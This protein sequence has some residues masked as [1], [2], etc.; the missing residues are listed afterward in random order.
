MAV[1]VIPTII[2]S[3]MMGVMIF[4]LIELNSQ[5]KKRQSF[6]LAGLLSLLLIHILG[7]LFIYSGAYR[8]APSLAGAQFPMRM[9]LGPAL[10]FYAF[11]SMSPKKSPP[12]MAWVLAVLGPMVVIL[13]MLPFVL[14]ISAQEKLALANP[15]TRDAEL[16]KVALFT[17]LFAMIAFIVF[18][19]IYLIAAFKL[20]QQHRR[21]LMERFADIEKRAMDWFSVLL[22]LWSCVWLLFAIDFS[23][24]FLG[25]KW[26]GTG[27][28]LP[29]AEALVLMFFCHFALRQPNINDADK[30]KPSSESVRTP[31][32]T[33]SKMKQIASK[34]QNIIAENALFLEDDLSLNKLS[35]AIAVSENHISETLSQY[36]QTNFFQFVNSYRV[37]HAMDLLISTNKTVTNIAFDAGFN[38]KSTF[39]TAFKK[40][41]GVTPTAYRNEA[42]S[43]A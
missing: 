7:E 11:A 32:L 6:Y 17:C 8:Y 2:Y 31:N 1:H 33:T 20:Q 38:S 40:V 28:V 39:N 24:N 3:S 5:T 9:L 36:L 29:L 4:A 19:G 26:F 34:L 35:A 16:F 23:L 22:V 14:G 30:G 10:Y 25:W 41:A 21:Q 13:G 42:K 43:S 27:I 18:T 12:K 37:K 15:A